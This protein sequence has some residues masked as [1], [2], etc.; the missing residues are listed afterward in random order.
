MNMV[1]V[2]WGLGSGVGRLGVDTDS[3]SRLFTGCMSFNQGVRISLLHISCTPTGI[4][5]HHQGSYVFVQSIVG[6]SDH[7]NSL[8]VYDQIQPIRM[9]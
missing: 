9:Q 2:A 4:K 7:N 3:K 1:E 5:D 8:L 6:D